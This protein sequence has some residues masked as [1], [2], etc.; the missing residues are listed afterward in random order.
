MAVDSV[1]QL[2]VRGRNAL[3]ELPRV[4]QP[5]RN[6]LTMALHELRRACVALWI[7]RRAQSHGR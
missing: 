2:P 7:Q 6:A 1:R 5:F 4:Q 3:Q